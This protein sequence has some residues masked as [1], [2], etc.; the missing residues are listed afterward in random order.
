M[1]VASESRFGATS[2]NQMSGSNQLIDADL[3]VQL[4]PRFEESPIVIYSV[5]IDNSRAGISE[6][7]RE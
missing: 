4:V 7:I 5:I 3:F 1:K 6:T 2:S